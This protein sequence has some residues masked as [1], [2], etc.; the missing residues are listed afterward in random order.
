VPVA[1]APSRTL[2][3]DGLDPVGMTWWGG[4]LW[5]ADAGGGRLVEIDPVTGLRGREVVC[6][7]VSGDL[8]VQA[9]LFLQVTGARRVVT[10]LDPATGRVCGTYANPRDG[11]HLAG[12]DARGADVLVGYADLTTLDTCDLVSATTRLSVDV[13][14]PVDGI[15]ITETAVLLAS[16][17]HSSVTIVP[18]DGGPHQAFEV[19]GSPAG[20][21]WDGVRLWYCD[22]SSPRV[23]ALDIP[24][25]AVV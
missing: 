9:G 16:T 2:V 22:R 1:L 11:Y 3:L 12:I 18:A 20:L 17:E 4:L 5:V 14:G 8:T 21:A 10:C 13:A 15:A 6:P 24:G 23:R 25:V 19:D 7:E